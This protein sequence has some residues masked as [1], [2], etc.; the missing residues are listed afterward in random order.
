[1]SGRLVAARRREIGLTMTPGNCLAGWRTAAAALGLLFAAIARGAAE[2][3]LERLKTAA[4][5]YDAT[6]R[7]AR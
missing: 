7:V 5:H 3:E 1:M 6:L 2:A 4:S